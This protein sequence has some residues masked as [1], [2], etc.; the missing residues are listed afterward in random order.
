MSKTIVLADDEPIIRLDLRTCLEE[1]G[2][3]VCAESSD[4][5]DGISSGDAMV[6][7]VRVR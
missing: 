6:V 2:Y 5:F 7:A 4:G 3:Q 1:Q